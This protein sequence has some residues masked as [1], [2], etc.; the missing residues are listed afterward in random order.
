MLV[1]EVLRVL[2]VQ[3]GYVELAC[4]LSR[5]QCRRLEV[6]QT[7]DDLEESIICAWG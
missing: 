3:Y 5:R 1:L 7:R 4:L 6:Y 2:Y